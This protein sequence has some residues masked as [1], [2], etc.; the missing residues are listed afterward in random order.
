VVDPRHD[1]D[2]VAVE[3]D[4][5]AATV[6]TVVALHGVS[7]ALDHLIAVTWGA[8]L[9]LDPSFEAPSAISP[10]L[11]HGTRTCVSVDVDTHPTTATAAAT[12]STASAASRQ[13]AA[14]TRATTTVPQS[15][16]ATD[17]IPSC[18]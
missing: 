5:H 2:P 16:R 14:T 11:N 18:P 17:V 13:P 1:A 3:R 9:A 8:V 6:E 12:V 10:I 7:V 4:D 15:V